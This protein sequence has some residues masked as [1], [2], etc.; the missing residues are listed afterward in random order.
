[1]E[2]GVFIFKPLSVSSTNR[3][4]PCLTA[5][6]C[7]EVDMA[8]IPTRATEHDIVTG[9]DPTRLRIFDTTLR[10]GEQAPGCTMTAEEKL[11]IA[12]QLKN[13]QVY[14]DK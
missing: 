2:G 13:L 4:M 5:H 14:C 9:R 3:G 11:S 1:M 12:R 10:D 6:V 7:K 8:P